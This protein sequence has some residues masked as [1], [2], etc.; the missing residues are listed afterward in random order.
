MTQSPIFENPFNWASEF[1]SPKLNFMSGAR[2][3]YSSTSCWTCR[4]RRVK[5]DR[6]LPECQKC[7]T[8]EEY[9]QGYSETRP[10][11]WTNGV[12]SR[13]KLMGKRLPI[14]DANKSSASIMRSLEDPAIQDLSPT[15]RGYIKYCT[16]VWKKQY[17]NC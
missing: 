14:I 10:L 11:R 3:D 5:C 17:Y 6:A 13:G 16:W 8:G 9:C 4:R 15:N 1:L 2:R 7:S 12:A